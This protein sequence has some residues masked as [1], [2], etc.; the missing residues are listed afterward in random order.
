MGFHSR[1]IY[2]V[3][4]SWHYSVYD[5]NLQGSPPATGA[6]RNDVVLS[7]NPN[8]VAPA[9]ELPVSGCTCMTSD[10]I[11]PLMLTEISTAYTQ[12][13]NSGSNRSQRDTDLQDTLDSFNS[14]DMQDTIT[15][16]DARKSSASAWSYPTTGSAKSQ[17]PKVPTSDLEDSEE[18]D[19]TSIE[20]PSYE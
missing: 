7:P 11:T 10:H 4:K 14:S 20:S 12:P 1:S 15:G 16:S 17:K 19:F 2:G 5:I 18:L 8:P 9:P 6:C 3:R 13:S